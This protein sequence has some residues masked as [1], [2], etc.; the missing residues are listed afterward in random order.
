[1]RL[2]KILI[3]RV[4]IGEDIPIRELPALTFLATFFIRYLIWI[5]S[6]QEKTFGST[7]SGLIHR[8]LGP[9]RVTLW[10]SKMRGEGKV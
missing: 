5:G 4:P 6:D 10:D 7:I 8:N 3:G 2:M 1:M 9:E